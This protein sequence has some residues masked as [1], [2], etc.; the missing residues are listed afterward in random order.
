MK[1]NDY[2]DFGYDIGIG[3]IGSAVI[4]EKDLRYLGVRIFNQ[5]TE[6]S[7][8]RGY[9]SARRNTKRKQWRRKQLKNAFVDFGLIK[10]KEINEEGYGSFTFK[11]SKFDLPKDRTVYHL[12]KRALK[13]KVNKREIYLCL[14][15]MLHARGHFNM[16]MYDFSKSTVSFDDYKDI[17]YS[18]TAPY[19]T[20]IDS[21]KKEFAE[22]YLN[23]IFSGEADKSLIRKAKKSRICEED[24]DAFENI[25][26]LLCGYKS[27]VLSI[28]EYF[29]NMKETVNINDIRSSEEEIP[30]FMMECVDLYDMAKIS[31][32]MKKYDYLCE[33]AVDEIDKYEKAILSGKESEEYKALIKELE[34]VSKGKHKRA[35]RNIDNNYPNALYVKEAR[36]ILEK[37]Q[38]YYKKEITDDFIDACVSIVSARIPYYIGPL[39][40]NAKNAWVKKDDSIPFKY[41]YAYTMKTSEGKA[42]DEPKSI[43]TWKERMISRCTYFPEEY[44]LPKGSLIAETHNILNELNILTAIDKDENRYYLTL[45]DKIKVFDD[46]FLKKKTIKYEEVAEL[47]GL[48]S[49]GPQKHGTKEPTFNNAFTLYHQIATIDKSLKLKTIMDIFDEAKKVDRIEEIVVAVNLYDEEVTKERALINDFGYTEEQAKKLAKLKS[50]S[51]YSFSK[52][53]V[54][55]QPIDKKGGTLLSKL[56]EDNSDKYTNEQMTL[57]SSAT[58]LKGNP[59]NFITNKYMQKLQNNDGRL[60]INLLIEEGKPVI[61][62]S[63]PVIR[64]LNECMKIY[65]EMVKVYGVPRRVIL[66]TARD[67]KDHTE[68][69]TISEKHFKKVESLYNHL[70]NQLKEKKLYDVNHIE[71]WEDIKAYLATNKTKIELYIR[72]NGTD[73]LTGEK[74]NINNLS[75]YE[76][77]HILPRGFGDDSKDDKMLISRLANAKK[78][79]RLPLEFIES[80]ET[81]GKKVISSSEYEKRVNSLFQTGLISEQKYKRLMLREP[82]LERFINQ[83]LVDTRYIIKEF[84]EILNAYNAYHGN[85]TKIVALKSAYTSLYR[86]AF[87]IKKNRDLGEQHHAHDAALLVVADRTLN[88][89]Y[90]NYDSRDI[91]KS[92][93][94]SLGSYKGFIKT[95]NDSFGDNE[96]ARSRSKQLNEFIKHAYYKAFNESSEDSHSLISI[97]KAT[98]PFYSLKVEKKFSGKFFEATILGQEDYKDKAPLAVIGVNDDKK[99]FKGVECAAV[100][101]YKFTNKKGNKEHLAVHIPKVIVSKDGIINK[102]KYLKLITDYY[103]KPELIDEKGELKTYLFK[104][105]AYKNDIIY[106]TVANCPMIFNI[107][108]IANKKLEKKFINIF[109]YDVIYNKSMNI[110]KELIDKFGVKEKDKSVIK[111]DDIGAEALI[112]YTINTI[113]SNKPEEKY[114]AAIMENCSKANNIYE[115]S[116]L[117]SYYELLLDRPGVP[118]TIIG[119]CNPVVNYDALNTNDN[120]YYIKLKYNILGLRFKFSE[121]DSLIIESPKEI[122]GAYSKIK[123]EEFSWQM[124]VLDI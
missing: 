82:E 112:K 83:N 11:S 60:D 64:S 56:F 44:A 85:I 117:L 5:A 97:I 17:F 91:K 55:I 42:I 25:L 79:D 88:T 59:I 106:D 68:V 113:W 7:E 69:G 99:V 10:E 52:K 77:D 80:G 20:I 65:S 38:E 102:E 90:P 72:Q 43:K 40:E 74:I 37:Q 48:K 67:F 123:K 34:G 100:D 118:P 96:E 103:E 15:N 58:D 73:L 61:A 29:S 84:M 26:N 92:K 111:Y 8:A 108:S 78:G 120:G 3:S 66:E 110:R 101:F 94:E 1:K 122:Q 9:R 71:D 86:K 16:E 57:L 32:I 30:T 33:K 87:N 95:M 53:L 75:D 114:I 2:V 62:M 27:K 76:I 46:L 36:S 18:I 115:L 19:I 39:N 51:F 14:L 12:R 107:G 41:S 28:S 47:L 116:D 119:R 13:E 31:Q 124:A 121:N 49:F 81:V 23:K 93:G 98:T 109:S 24:I 105:R 35:W 63:R 50:N 70:E 89:Y 6:A 104:F 4:G 21:S 22:E 45:E 54:M